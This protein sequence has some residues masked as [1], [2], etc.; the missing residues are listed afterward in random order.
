[1][2][3]QEEYLEK[4][5]KQLGIKNYDKAYP[6]FKEYMDSMKDYKTNQYDYAPELI[7][8]VNERLGFYF[9]RY[10]YEMIRPE[11]AE[12]AAKEQA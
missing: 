10:G 1:M 7:E 3:N 11:R 4:I 8:K 12:T 6:Y 9:E 2:E 5:Y